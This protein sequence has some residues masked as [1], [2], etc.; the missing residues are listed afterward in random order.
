M[1]IDI[2]LHTRFSKCSDFSV[3]ELAREVER[4]GM[5]WVTV[6]DHGTAEGCEELGRR[7]AGV[8]VIYGVEVTTR[9]GDFLVFCPDGEYIRGLTLYARSVS[10]LRDGHA[11]AAIVWA[12]PRG[13]SPLG[14]TAPSADSPQV[15][16]VMEHVDAV[17][18]YNA[19]MLT[20][21]MHMGVDAA[22]YARGVERLAMEYNKPLTGGSDAHAREQ[23]M[24]CWTEF[25]SPVKTAEDFTAA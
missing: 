18:L 17:E 3:E 13:T 5:E 24:T 12:H 16:Y 21:Q 10:E 14:W 1:R 6:T 9:E 22:E 19:R 7:L 11:G 25:A 20:G 15:R 8:G 23:F 2:H 4:R